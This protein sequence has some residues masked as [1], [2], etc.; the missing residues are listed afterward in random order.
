MA[1][2][3]FEIGTEEIPAGFLT[4]AL[5]DLPRLAA[6][7]LDA[8][9]LKHGEPR[10]LGTPRRLTLVVADLAER[11]EDVAEDLVGPPAKVAFK[12]GQPTKAA[13]AFA[14]K[15]GVDV[16]AIKIV[17][18]EKGDYC[19]AR[20]EVAGQPARALLP[21]ILGSLIRELPFKKSMR[22]AAHDEA[23]VRPVHWLLA[24]FEG[25]VVPLEFAG[26]KSGNTTCGQRFLS[27]DPVVVTDF[28]DYREKLR[29]GHVVVDRAH[30]RKMVVDEIARLEAESGVKV[31]DDPGLVD[32]VTNLV[33]HPW[34]VC[35]SF[36]EKFLEVPREVI[37]TAMRSH[38]RYFAMVDG[39]GQL[40]NRF[41][42]MAGTKTRDMDLV[43]RGNER[44]LAA[45]LS[46]ARFFFAED[47]KVKLDERAGRLGGVVFINKLGTQAER[48]ARVRALALGLAQVVGAE[49]A[50]V[51]RAAE[52]CKVDLTTQMVGEFPELQG[53]MGREYALRQGE[54]PAV[55]DA[56]LEHYLPRGASDR[57]PDGLV[58]A[59]LGVAD[60]VDAIVGCFGVGL[61][62]TGSADPFALRRAALGIL[63]IV[64]A[65][66]W[67]LSLKDLALNAARGYAKPQFADV[68]PAVLDFFKGRLRGVFTEVNPTDVVD[69]AL[70]AGFDDVVDARERTKALAALRQRADFEPIGVAF[71]RV[72]NILKGEAVAEGPAGL[73]GPKIEPEEQAL[74]DAFASLEQRV[75]ALV[76]A[77][78]YAAALQ[79]LTT[80]RP[81]VDLFFDKVLVMDP[82]PAIKARRLGLLGRINR[83]FKSIADFRQLSV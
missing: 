65:R 7:K 63:Q 16:S 57:L 2:L 64:L 3:L 17:P 32:E 26:V 12:D 20:R 56:I 75:G 82:D 10:A 11:Q 66:G 8:A 30:R 4:Q 49:V 14:K 5:E 36:D 51:A 24:L 54:D 19:S 81:A 69:A 9:R 43:R 77:H 70:A 53:V 40:V 25:Q 15:A 80:L 39:A 29:K 23:F 78:D 59:V 46:D 42:T 50:Q 52:L 74:A 48:V 55:A 35:G 18:T 73:T 58:G 38:Q 47:Q 45:R 1:E 21:E 44:V 71:K 37:V 6:K 31:I 62:P 41:V 67:R 83:L 33:E 76:A 72:A 61:Q 22:W 13:E 60:R 28:L 27:P 68:V 34:G 79:D